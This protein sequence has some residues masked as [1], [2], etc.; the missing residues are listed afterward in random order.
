VSAGLPRRPS[1]VPHDV[2]LAELIR[3]YDDHVR[4]VVVA[5]PRIGDPAKAEAMFEH[6]V[7]AL[8][9]AHAVVDRLFASRWSTVRDA[10]AADASRGQEVAAACWLDPDE[11]AV[12]LSNW[13]DRQNREGL[14]PDVEYRVV[15][16]LA[17]GVRW[18]R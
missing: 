3:Q 11:V 16:L 2:P 6:A 9:V 12:G 8:A 10:L 14:M 1:D 17:R 18:D 7:A 4:D 15:V 13:A 5:R